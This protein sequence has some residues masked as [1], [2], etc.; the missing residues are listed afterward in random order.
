MLH[1]PD[2]VIIL[3]WSIY[4]ILLHAKYQGACLIIGAFGDYRV[5]GHVCYS[6]R[7]PVTIL[8]LSCLFVCLFVCLSVF[9]H[10]FSKSIEGTEFSLST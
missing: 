9:P 5:I 10:V 8:F 7:F 3:Q 6:N 4:P 2:L 1:Q